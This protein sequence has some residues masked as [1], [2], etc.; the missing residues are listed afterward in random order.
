MK[1]VLSLLFPRFPISLI[2]I[3]KEDFANVLRVPWAL[4]EEIPVSRGM[5]LV[6]F[7]LFNG[8]LNISI[9]HEV[10]YERDDFF[11]P[12]YLLPYGED[13]KAAAFR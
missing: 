5:H 13:G 2:Y 11:Y 4:R 6:A 12:Y 8:K 7:S 1:Q 10:G 9:I 3:D